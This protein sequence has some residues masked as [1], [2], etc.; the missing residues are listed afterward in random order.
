M[1]KIEAV[2]PY[3]HKANALEVAGLSKVVRTPLFVDL[4][5]VS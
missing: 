3:C 2:C 5:G 1:S 4:T